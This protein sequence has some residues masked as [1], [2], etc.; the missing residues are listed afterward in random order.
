MEV[1]WSGDDATVEPIGLPR[2]MERKGR[3]PMGA[4]LHLRGM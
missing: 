3:L 2:L 1:D 4:G